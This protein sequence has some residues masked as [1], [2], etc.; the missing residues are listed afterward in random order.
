M[1]NADNTKYDKIMVTVRVMLIIQK[2]DKLII[3]IRIMLINKNKYDKI[4]YNHNA[5]SFGPMYH[6]ISRSN[7]IS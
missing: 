6:M 2:Y 7:S 5:N 4:I 3:I 1:I